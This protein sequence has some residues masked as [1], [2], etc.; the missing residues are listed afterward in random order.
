MDPILI[1]QLVSNPAYRLRVEKIARKFTGS[2]SSLIWEDVAQEAHEKVIQALQAGKF[3]YQTTEKLY[4]WAATVA[5]HE[6]SDIVKREQNFRKRFPCWSLDR[7][8]PGTD[9]PLSESIA[10]SSEDLLTCLEQQEQVKNLTEVV[11]KLDR[12]Y[13]DRNY[14]QIFRMKYSAEPMTQAQIA[15]ALNITQSAISK[16]LR[17]LSGLLAE[18][19]DILNMTMIQQEQQIIGQQK[20]SRSPQQWEC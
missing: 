8:I 5:H 1:E 7:T 15:Q 18:E 11:N 13:P 16:R 2:V 10:D 12:A 19:L 4:G 20:R 9:V 6:I 17:E 14:L 3:Q